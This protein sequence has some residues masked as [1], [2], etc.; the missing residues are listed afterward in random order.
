VT[1]PVA[2][3]AFFQWGWTSDFAWLMLA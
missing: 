3:I 1:I 2:L